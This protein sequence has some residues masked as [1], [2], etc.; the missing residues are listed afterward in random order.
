MNH[1]ILVAESFNVAFTSIVT[2]LIIIIVL[3][4]FGA[5][6]YI[7]LVTVK[8]RADLVVLQQKQTVPYPVLDKRIC[9]LETDINVYEDNIFYINRNVDTICKNIHLIQHNLLNLRDTAQGEQLQNSHDEVY[10]R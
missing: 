9:T 1:F 3:T 7:Y 2:F 5:I 8:L 4:L 10:N 6:I